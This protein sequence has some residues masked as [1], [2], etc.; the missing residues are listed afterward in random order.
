MEQ[1]NKNALPLVEQP[2]IILWWVGN[3]GD[4]YD[5]D[6]E[7]NLGVY[8]GFAELSKRE[9]YKDAGKLLTEKKADSYVMAWVDE[10]VKREVKGSKRVTINVSVAM[11]AWSAAYNSLVTLGPTP[12][13]NGVLKCSENLLN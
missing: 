8:F 9:K 7:K 3:G 10:E 12:S 2:P 6:D 13:V 11:R 1:A 4:D 5:Y